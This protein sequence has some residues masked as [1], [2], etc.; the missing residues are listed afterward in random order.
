L[1][2]SASAPPNAIIVAVLLRR[3]HSYTPTILVVQTGLIATLAIGAA[4]AIPA[5]GIALGV[6]FVAG[7]Q[8]N[9]FH[10]D[11]GMLY[12]NVAM[13]FVVQS[14]FSLTGRAIV[15]SSETGRRE[16]LG[17]AGIYAGVLVAFAVGAAAGF[18]LEQALNTGALW[19]GATVTLALATMSA[20]QPDPRRVDPAQNSPTP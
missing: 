13:T 6:S 18:L 12:G 7:S 17:A 4:A 2:R 15:P 19:V 10:R 14:L 9:T 5:M 16:D 1:S 8:G 11:H 20:T 3:G